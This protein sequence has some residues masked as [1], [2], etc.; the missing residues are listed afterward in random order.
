MFQMTRRG[1]KRRNEK[2]IFFVI[3]PVDKIAYDT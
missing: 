2:M 1:W 3:K